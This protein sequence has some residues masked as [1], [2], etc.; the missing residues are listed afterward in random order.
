M[1][2]EED[3]TLAMEI[4]PNVIESQQPKIPE[5]LNV[6]GNILVHGQMNMMSSSVAAPE[7]GRKALCGEQ[8]PVQDDDCAAE[9]FLE[10]LP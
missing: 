9:G 4:A 8:K 2:T 1:G 6:T 3:F 7:A 10:L 5:V